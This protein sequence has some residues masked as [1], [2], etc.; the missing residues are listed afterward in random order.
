ML[1]HILQHLRHYYRNQKNVT[2]E[3]HMERKSLTVFDVH[4][5]LSWLWPQVCV[6]PVSGFL[7][8]QTKKITKCVLLLLH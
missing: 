8:K 5:A 4:K 1:K 3:F 2:I 6:H 7:L